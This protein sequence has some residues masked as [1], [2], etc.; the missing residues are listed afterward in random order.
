LLDLDKKIFLLVTLD[1]YRMLQAVEKQPSE[2]SSS[3]DEKA[4]I[5]TPASTNHQQRDIYVRRLD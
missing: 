5:Q 3:Y 1:M 2:S 4:T